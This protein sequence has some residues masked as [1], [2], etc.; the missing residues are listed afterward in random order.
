MWEIEDISKGNLSLRNI[1]LKVLIV[2]E[3]LRLLLDLADAVETD[4]NKKK[5][6]GWISSTEM[7]ENFWLAISQLIDVLVKANVVE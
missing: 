7:D 3:L 1:L 5:V 6:K 2:D 4:N